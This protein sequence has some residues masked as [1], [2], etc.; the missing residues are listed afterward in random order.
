MSRT[1]RPTSETHAGRNIPVGPFGG[2]FLPR[3]LRPI[4]CRRIVFQRSAPK[5]IW[6]VESSQKNGFSKNLRH[7]CY[8]GCWSSSAFDFLATF[9]DFE[10]K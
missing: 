9:E 6:K 4:V 3:C 8:Q 1:A 5:K 7:S 2:Q 10:E